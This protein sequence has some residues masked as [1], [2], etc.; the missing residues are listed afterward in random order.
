MWREVQAMGEAKR[1]RERFRDYLLHMANEWTFPPSEWETELVEEL[2]D[3]S[4]LLVSRLGEDDIQ[5]MRMRMSFAGALPFTRVAGGASSWRRLP[6]ARPKLG[7]RRYAWQRPGSAGG[8]D[9]P[10]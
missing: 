8:D 9:P 6:P 3:Q 10:K 1:Q 4:A 2:F 5:W 7:R